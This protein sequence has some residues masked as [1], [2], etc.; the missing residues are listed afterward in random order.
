M[1]AAWTICA[2]HSPYLDLLIMTATCN[3]QESLK[4]LRAGLCGTAHPTRAGEGAAG[5]QMPRPR[6]C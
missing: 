6:Q 1:N 4:V 3:I 2:G 5:H